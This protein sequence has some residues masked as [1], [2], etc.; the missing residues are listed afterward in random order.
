MFFFN[1]FIHQSIKLKSITGSK[2]KKKIK[3]H[4]NFNIDNNQHIRMICE[5][6]CDTEDWV[7]ADEIS[8]LHNINK[9]YFK[10][11]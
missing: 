11:Y 6:S 4:N 9:L 8:V 2:K 5:G 7:M 1:I 3:Q 10:V